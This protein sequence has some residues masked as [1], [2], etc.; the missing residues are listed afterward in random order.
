M[1]PGVTGMIVATYYSVGHWNDSSY[2]LLS[3]MIVATYYSVGH[4]N[5]SSYLLLSGQLE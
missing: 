1:T 4:W 2:L 3:G 5:D